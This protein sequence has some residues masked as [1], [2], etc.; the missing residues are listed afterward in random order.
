ML[1]TEGTWPGR[2]PPSSQCGF[3][4]RR[5]GK[6]AAGAEPPLRNGHS[7]W[8][9]PDS[10]PK[11]RTCPDTTNYS[12]V[13]S[14]R[15]GCLRGIGRGFAKVQIYRSGGAVRF[16]RIQI[17]APAAAPTTAAVTPM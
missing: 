8:L 17:N 7:A 11:V 9:G 3:E 15:V 10:L 14:R 6:S 12:R 5:R 1:H 4:S 13:D 2:R 16:L